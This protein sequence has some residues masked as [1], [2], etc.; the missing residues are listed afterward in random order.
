MSD[1]SHGPAG[2]DEAREPSIFGGFRDSESSETETT[3]TETT[4]TEKVVEH[5]LDFRPEHPIIDKTTTSKTTTTKK[6]EETMSHDD[7][8]TPSKIPPKK[9]GI[10][11][12]EEA[13][14]HKEG[15]SRTARIIGWLLLLLAGIVIYF[16]LRNVWPTTATPAAKTKTEVKAE[17]PKDPVTEPATKTTTKV[18]PVDEDDSSETT[19]DETKELSLYSLADL[20]SMKDTL[21]KEIDAKA[22]LDKIKT[23]LAADPDNM[24]LMKRKVKLLEEKNA[25]EAAAR[26]VRATVATAFLDED[27]DPLVLLNRRIKRLEF[28]GLNPVGQAHLETAHHTARMADAFEEGNSIAR[29]KNEIGD[30]IIKLEGRV[31]TLETSDAANKTAIAANTKADDERNKATNDRIDELTKRVDSMEK[32]IASLSLTKGDVDTLTERLNVLK[33]RVDRGEMTQGDFARILE[34]LVPIIQAQAARDAAAAQ[35]AAQPVPFY[36][37]AQVNGRWCGRR[38]R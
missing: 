25:A 16:I 12:D 32:S 18:V 27:T 23:K 11:D 21:V 6:G 31:G 17:D 1:T 37:P 36:Q 35:A 20:K 38:C 9:P 10:L 28:E 5:P 24:P 14:P 26:K 19:A 15:L 22:A 34:K 2:S 30:A 4:T 8:K 3:T 33:D 29:K 7:H 13:P